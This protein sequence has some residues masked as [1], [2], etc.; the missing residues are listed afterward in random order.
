MITKEKALAE[1]EEFKRRGVKHKLIVLAIFLAFMIVGTSFFTM[2]SYLLSPVKIQYETNYF[3]AYIDILMKSPLIGLLIL[4]ISITSTYLIVKH[5]KLDKKPKKDSRGIEISESNEEGSSHPMD[6]QEKHDFFKII[7]PESLEN[8]NSE[9]IIIAEDKKTKKLLTI[10]WEYD[11]PNKRPPNRNMCVF[12]YSGSRK[13]SSI[14]I[15]EIYNNLRRGNSLVITDPKGE[16]AMETYAAAVHYG[17]K[18]RILNLLPEQFKMSDGWDMLKSIKESTDPQLTAEMVTNILINNTGTAG[19][20]GPQFWQ[21]SNVNCLKLALLYVA[22]S[23]HFYSLAQDD[24]A[25]N[26]KTVYSLLS[27]TFPYGKE[28][29]SKKMKDII[30]AAINFDPKDRELLAQPYQ[31][32]ASNSQ[33]ESIQ[34]GLA[35]R[36]SIFQSDTLCKV[37]SE[38]EINFE[39]LDDKENPAIFYILCSDND[40]TY[41]CILTLFSTFLFNSM[42]AIADKKSTKKLNRPLSV[43]FEEM[44][45]IGKIPNLSKLVS[46]LRS[47]DIS[48]TFCYQTLGQLID[49]YSD[50]IG[51]H[52]E[53]EGIIGNCFLY[54]STG[55]RD[56]TTKKFLSEISGKMTIEKRASGRDLPVFSPIKIAFTER[57]QNTK[58]GRPVYMPDEIEKIQ[59]NE[60]MIA[61]VRYNCTIEDKYFY[62]KHPDYRLRI[63]SYDGTPV[64]Y[65]HHN[66]LPAWRR[67]EEIKLKRIHENTTAGDNQILDELYKSEE[68]AFNELKLQIV[69]TEE[70]KKKGNSYKKTVKNIPVNVSYEEEQEQEKYVGYNNFNIFHRK[71]TYSDNY[72]EEVS[73]NSNQDNNNETLQTDTSDSDITRELIYQQEQIEQ[74]KSNYQPP[75]TSEEEEA[76]TLEEEER[77]QQEEADNILFNDSYYY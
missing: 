22:K 57:M 12:G 30:E 61:P 37:L 63:L 28:T 6:D 23:K 50:K 53:W 44:A 33:V 48:M 55:S 7:S 19:Q 42:Y 21:D 1:F 32:W 43:I 31:I 34:S 58:V 64:K 40:D 24:K 41:K 2:L 72:F 51:S 8:G 13:S 25:R 75:F 76:K 49:I 59:A 69:D 26:I 27:D 18:I 60:I 4:F 3:L 66:H 45:N 15:A 47:R 17:Y 70:Y 73:Y 67:K 29:S 68:F 71:P 5:V 56:Q 39:E 74:E 11:D 62:K 16:M 14:L 36:L 77:R 54:L 52:Y 65:D 20:A 46:T 38:D 10:P 35:I 9:G